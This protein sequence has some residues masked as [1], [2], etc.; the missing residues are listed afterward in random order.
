MWRGTHW[1]ALVDAVKKKYRHVATRVLD[2]AAGDADIP[3][4]MA[5]IP[6]AMADIP[7]VRA[8]AAAQADGGRQ[9]ERPCQA[10]HPAP[11][12]G[13]C[14]ITGYAVMIHMVL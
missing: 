14:V 3:S 2:M 4:A 7:A 8:R 9:H 5:D 1:K 13:G 12:D 11:D 6:S 10:H